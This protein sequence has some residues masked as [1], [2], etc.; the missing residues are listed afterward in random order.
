MDSLLQPDIIISK[1]KK[2]RKIAH[3]SKIFEQ[4]SFTKIQKQNVAWQARI[5]T[6]RHTH[7]VEE[8]RGR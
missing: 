2:K 1:K 3:I 5:Y 8:A 4:K 6:K 7:W